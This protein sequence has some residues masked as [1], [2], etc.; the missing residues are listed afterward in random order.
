MARRAVGSVPVAAAGLGR[1][2]IARGAS[3]R[4]PSTRRGARG[5]AGTAAMLFD[6][7]RGRK[8]LFD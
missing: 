8:G 2:A 1:V 7:A 3:V 4:R 6:R 5:P